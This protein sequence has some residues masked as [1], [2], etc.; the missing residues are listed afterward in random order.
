MATRIL[1]IEDEPLLVSLY[2]MVLAK[3][4]Y[5]V[6][7]AMDAETAEEKVVTDRP[8]VVLLDLMIP[9][10]QGADLHDSS[11]HEPTGFQILRLVKSTPSLQDIR[12]IVLSNLDSD[13]HVKTAT[14]LGADAYV[15]KANLDPHDLTRRVEDVLHGPGSAKPIKITVSQE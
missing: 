10:A 6:M 8:H 3:A 14:N 7:S 9:K 12:V 1:L 2:T 11:L 15:V 4:A 13:E 5:D